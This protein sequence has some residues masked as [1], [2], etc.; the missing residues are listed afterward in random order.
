MIYMYCV[1]DTKPFAIDCSEEEFVRRMQSMLDANAADIDNG[2]CLYDGDL[3]QCVFDD[4]LA[5]VPASAG[6]DQAAI[7]IL[8]GCEHVSVAYHDRYYWKDY[9]FGEWWQVID[10]M[11]SGMY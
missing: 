9:A 4:V 3:L 5:P 7:W 2:Y 1:R 11:R 10:A 6:N 8:V